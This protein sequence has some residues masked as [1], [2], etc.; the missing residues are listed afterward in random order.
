MLVLIP[1]VERCPF[2]FLPFPFQRPNRP[3]DFKMNATKTMTATK[4]IT[5]LRCDLD[6]SPLNIDWVVVRQDD[7]EFPALAAAWPESVI[8]ISNAEAFGDG[9]RYSHAGAE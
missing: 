3:K 2:L 5:V 8:D 1:P 9:T 7:A 6:G 4:E